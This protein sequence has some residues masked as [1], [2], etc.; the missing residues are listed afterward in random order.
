[1]RGLILG[2]AVVLAVLLIAGEGWAGYISGQKLND[3]CSSDDFVDRAQ[4]IGYVQGAYDAGKV[5]DA[6]TDKRFWEGGFTS[7]MPDSV[8]TGQLVEVVKKSLREQPEDWHYNAAGLVARA[9]DDAFPC[10]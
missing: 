2:L 9:V 4:C 1:M 7:C 6:A 5:L 8:L 10:R 3:L